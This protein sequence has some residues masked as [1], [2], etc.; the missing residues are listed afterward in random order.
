MECAI[1]VN[2]PKEGEAI[3]ARY[4]RW[5]CLV[6]SHPPPNLPPWKGG[7][8]NWGG[9]ECEVGGGLGEIPAASAGVPGGMRD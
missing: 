6:A 1:S 5:R 8:M 3:G 2:C 9:G 4:G 7:G